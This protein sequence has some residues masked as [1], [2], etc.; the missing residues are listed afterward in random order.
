ME[1]LSN[2][3]KVINTLSDFKTQ[4]KTH[5]FCLSYNIST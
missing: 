3:I 4:L 5:L 1:K 2:N